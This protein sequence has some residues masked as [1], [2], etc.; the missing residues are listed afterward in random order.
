MI[1]VSAYTLQDNLVRTSICHDR[2]PIFL[3]QILCQHG[4]SLLH[5]RQL[6]IVKHRTGHVDQKHEVGRRC[7]LEIDCLRIHGN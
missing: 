1:V 5:K 3:G 4:K 2:Y 7:L 6:I